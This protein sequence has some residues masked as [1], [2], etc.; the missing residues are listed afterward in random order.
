MS[1]SD[2]PIQILIKLRV[3][4]QF[5]DSEFVQLWLLFWQ[6]TKSFSFFQQM[7]G[8]KTFKS[9]KSLSE[10]THVNTTV[11]FLKHTSEWVRWCLWGIWTLR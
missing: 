9:T 6:T 3:E 5:F 4:G 1:L 7:F 2:T 10:I 11:D 8:L